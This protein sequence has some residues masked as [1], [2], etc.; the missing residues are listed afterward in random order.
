MA[1]LIA[2]L[3]AWLVLHYVTP[4]RA[5]FTLKEIRKSMQPGEEGWLALPL[6]KLEAQ[7]R[8]TLRLNKQWRV[9]RR[10]TKGR[11]GLREA[12]AKVD[13][14]L[15]AIYEALKRVVERVAAE[16]PLHKAAQRLLNAHF[17]DGAAALTR[18]PVAE[19]L[20][21]A[22]FLLETLQAEE[23]Q[24]DVRDLGLNLWR[25]QLAEALPGYGVAIR[26]SSGNPLGFPEVRAARIELQE[27]LAAVA[28]AIL[29]RTVDDGAARERL[30][31]PID[32]QQAE[33]SALHR[34]R[35]R[36]RDVDEHT[37]QPVDGEDD[38][39]DSPA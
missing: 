3:A 28:L 22:E 1:L 30:M 21:E 39:A 25:D 4:G 10:L 8:T 11:A 27:R 18:L 29:G 15:G 7:A 19:E 12:D 23:N 35:T 34:A 24:A 36:L 32:Q 33:L 16:N 31:G 13:S 20:E 5:L 17:P 6:D 37:G 38:E 26:Q 14:I 9:V 2:G